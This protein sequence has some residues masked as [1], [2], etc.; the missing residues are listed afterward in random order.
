MRIISS[1]WCV[2]LLLLLAIAV[3]ASHEPRFHVRPPSNWI[4]DPNGP[5]RDP[6]TK[7]MHLYMQY[8]PY[9]AVWGNMSWYHFTSMDY[10][11]WRDQGVA[12]R[13]DEEYDLW[14]AYTGSITYNP[15]GTPVMMY[16][17]TAVENIQRQ[18]LALPPPEDIAKNGPRSLNTFVKVDAN[19]VL[20]EDDMP[21]L[22]DNFNYRDPTNFWENPDNS[23]EWLF[24]LAVRTRKD[25]R[26][27]IVVFSTGDPTW[28]SGFKYSH[29]IWHEEFDSYHMMEC[30]DIFKV[31]SDYVLKVSTMVSQ[32]DM[33]VY[34]NYGAKNN[35]NKTIY[36]EDSE[37]TPTYMDYGRFY[38]AKHNFDPVLKRAVL[39]GWLVEEDTEEAMRARGWSGMMDLP[40]YVEY[41]EKAK[42][43]KSFPMPQLEQLRLKPLLKNKAVKIGAN[44]RTAL[45][46]DA[47]RYY[48]LVV[49]FTLPEGAFKSGTYEAGKEPSFGVDLLSSADHSSYTRIA[50]AMPGTL[51][52]KMH[53]QT[54][55]HYTSV[56]VNESDMCKKKCETER[57]CV[58]WT[59]VKIPNKNTS[60]CSVMSTFGEAR[61]ANE[62]AVTGRISEPVI[63]LDRTHSGTTGSKEIWV[64]RAPLWNGNK[65]QLRVFL[66]DTAVQVF[67]DGGLESLSG[68]VYVDHK[69]LTDLSL[70]SAN[71]A[72][73]V[74]AVVSLYPMDTVIIADTEKPSPG[75]GSSKICLLALAHLL[76][77]QL[78]L[79][80]LL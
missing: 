70:F 77:A 37:R 35:E 47:G 15:D 33:W 57:R 73:T 75:D 52:S 4:N 25:D 26:G 3:T 8:N 11:K 42:K 51:D 60:R 13:N 50:V 45:V 61:A 18:C 72:E 7:Q 10:V 38:A 76:V 69:K 12:M 74:E 6:I 71:I 64:G 17:C 2:L 34:G 43:M 49:D 48:E 78:V 5:Y 32:Q 55:R 31:G 39:W 29:S 63:L 22:Y 30:P 56:E 54:G 27:H 44:D 16:T 66:D 46:G 36:L 40:R 28:R 65:V 68:R 79:Y 80:F 62:S 20:T 41:D 19:P 67:K 23:S 24:A 53:D 1:T 9:G 59:A 14:G 58:A 21:D